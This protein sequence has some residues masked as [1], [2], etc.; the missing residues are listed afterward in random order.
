MSP[1]DIII[2][3]VKPYLPPILKPLYGQVCVGT[4][5]C[6]SAGANAL[7]HGTLISHYEGPRLK[8]WAMNCVV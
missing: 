2:A 3:V 8:G 1:R 6:A 5:A 7:A 4:C